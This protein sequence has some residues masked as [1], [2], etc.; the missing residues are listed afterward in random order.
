MR[1]R[2]VINGAKANNLALKEAITKIRREHFFALDIKIAYLPKDIDKIVKVSAQDGITRLIA[3]GGDGT[4]NQ[5]LNSIMELEPTKR[6]ELAIAPL[7][8][9]NDFAK[10]ANIP[11]EIYDALLLAINGKSYPIDI[12][13]ANSRYFINVASGG[14]GAKIT[15]QTPPELKSILGGGAYAL[16]GLLNIFNFTP[17][18][19]YMRIDD[20]EFKESAFATAI[21]NGRQAG[22]GIVLSPNAIIDNG[23]LDIVLFMTK[24]IDIPNS[25]TISSKI[26]LI[27]LPFRKIIR[28]SNIEFIPESPIEH[29]NLDGE[30]LR[31]SHFKFSILHKVLNCILPN[32]CPLLL[33]NAK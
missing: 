1:I 31:D 3:G 19:G 13:K 32:K 33:R 25:T 17:V 14:F 18:K 22:G 23:F 30:P 11:L 21:C 15:A 10:S 20:F 8:T 24:E 4:I 29:I 2:M 27:E 7:G 28:A 16:T 26:T 12:G 9:A 6:P 5:V